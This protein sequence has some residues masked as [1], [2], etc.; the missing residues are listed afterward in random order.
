[1]QSS[2]DGGDAGM[3]PFIRSCIEFM[4]PLSVEFN[5]VAD[6]DSLLNESRLSIGEGVRRRMLATQVA[7]MYRVRDTGC[8]HV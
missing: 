1:V 6:A 7:I 4:A 8:I 5:S 2:L 3:F